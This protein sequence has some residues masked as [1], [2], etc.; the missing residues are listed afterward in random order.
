MK[1]SIALMLSFSLAL[2]LVGCSEQSATLTRVE[3][4]ITIDE[5]I[6]K[7]VVVI[8]AQETLELIQNSLE[9]VTWSPNTL[10]E[11]VR[12]EDVCITLFYTFDDNT[13]ESSYVYRIWFN[14][15]GTATI[16]SSH[17]REGFGKLDQDYSQ[18]LKEVLIQ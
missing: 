13:T 3:V 1:K 17:E 7:D 5:E 2:L 4:Q 15:D 8:T 10:P 12:K 16:I 18:K 6:Y 11:M 14:N 9:K